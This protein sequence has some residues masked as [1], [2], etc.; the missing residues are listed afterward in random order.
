MRKKLLYGLLLT[1][2]VAVLAY[3]AYDLLSRRGKS[4]ETL[5]NF[6]ISDTNAITAIK[7]R[8]GFGKEIMLIKKGNDWQDE[9]GNCVS[10][11]N[12]SYILEAAKLI[13][14]KGYLPDSSLEKFTN[15]M[16]T[17]HIKVDF[18]VHG[19]WEKTWYIGPPAQ[20]HY[21]QIMLLESAK[22]GKSKDP[23]MM[24]I[25]GLNGIIGPRF[26]ADRKQWM[27]TSIFALSPEE[28]QSVNVENLENSSL[29]FSIQKNQKQ[30]DVRSQGVPLSQVDTAN[31]YRYLQGY[32]KVHYNSAN[33]ELSSVQCDSV[34]NTKPFA[35]LTLR[36]TNGTTTV[37]KMFRIRSIEPQRNEL[38]EM[39]NMDLNVFW[40]ELP[41]RSLVK[42]QYFV[43]NPLLMGYV[44]FPALNNRK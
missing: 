31:I 38:G 29:S 14:F 30:F 16:T 22:D 10:R 44:Y 18:F 25:R 39:V 11:S 40:A 15:L 36:Q 35:K 7:I 20:D 41:N 19:A 23:V 33:F 9:A 37:L 4:D 21:G 2:L 28:I 17:Q 6:S 34:R 26:F 24:R 27:C 32:K 43:F 12:I 3:M 8:D 1:A 42:C 5:F 13:E